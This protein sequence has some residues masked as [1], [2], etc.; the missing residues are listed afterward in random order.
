MSEH[1]IFQTEFKASAKDQNY[2]V[3][4]GKFPSSPDK[5]LN[6]CSYIFAQ[7]P[8]ESEV[9]IYLH[10][11]GDDAL[12]PG[13]IFYTKLIKAG[14]GVFAFDLPGHGRLSS[15][16]F[17]E[18]EL[19]SCVAQAV[20]LLASWGIDRYHL[21]G[22]SL[23]GVVAIHNVREMSLSPLTL[24]LLGVP[25]MVKPE[26]SQLIF[27]L[28]YSVG[29]EFL[30][31]ARVNGFVQMLPAFG[32]FKRRQFPVRAGEA[33]YLKAVSEY[34]HCQFSHLDRISSVPTLAINGAM[35][36]IAPPSM[37]QEYLEYFSQGEISVFPK[38][39]HFMLNFTPLVHD[40]M[41]EYMG[42]AA[43]VF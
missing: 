38:I 37:A 16:V 19:S 33:H 21:V 6:E 26:L 27:E 40:R 28:R 30:K 14:Y 13:G 25:T 23:G 18:S 10:G 8:Q 12:Y 32:P 5:P 1:H 3:I 41:L 42:H 29:A 39:N 2:R 35:D 36:R 22:Y 4:Q 11:T 20:K 43:R 17:E 7:P 24:I 31:L 15:S 34:I 9:V